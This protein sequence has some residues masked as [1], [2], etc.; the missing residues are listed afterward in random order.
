M[1]VMTSAATPMFVLTL[2]VDNRNDADRSLS[3]ATKRFDPG[4]RSDM[5]L[6]P[7]SPSRRC[8]K[9]KIISWHSD[10]ARHATAIMPD[11]DTRR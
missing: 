11:L 7:G 8:G 9:I 5:T 1:A 6:P 4:C 3:R 10:D 2:F